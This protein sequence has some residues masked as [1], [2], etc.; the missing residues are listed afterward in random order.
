MGVIGERKEMT[1]S[2][3]SSAFS[4]EMGAGTRYVRFVVEA[5]NVAPT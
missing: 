3:G 5:S 4:V 1:I 2:I